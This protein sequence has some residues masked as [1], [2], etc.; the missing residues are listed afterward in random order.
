MFTGIVRGVC[1]VAATGRRANSLV[2]ELDLGELAAQVAVGDSVLVDGV[3]LTATRGHDGRTEFDVAAETLRLT[4]LGSLN[5]GG[6]VNV[7]LALRPTD[8]FGGHFVS[9]HVDGVGTIVENPSR[10]GDTMLKVRVPAAMSDQMVVKGSV[11]VDGISLTIAALGQ[12]SFEV[13]LIPHTLAVTTL[14]E[15]RPGERVN[16][17]CDMIGK[18]VRKCV[19]QQRP[20]GLTLERLEEAGF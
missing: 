15:K 8:R 7:E 10:P 6:R 3:C 13:S 19:E 1:S 11:A 14:G 17:E 20:Q 4:T 18:W 2:L 16:V 9:G 5:P 12:D